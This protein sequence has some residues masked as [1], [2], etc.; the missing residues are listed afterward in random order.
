MQNFRDEMSWLLTGQIMQMFDDVLKWE[1]S[2]MFCL[3][4]I[5]KFVSGCK[6]QH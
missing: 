2:K 4:C 5:A 6:T 1:L 3:S